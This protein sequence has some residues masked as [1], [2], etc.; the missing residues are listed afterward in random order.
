MLLTADQ[1]RGCGGVGWRDDA[2][3]RCGQYGWAPL[4]HGQT[5]NGAKGFPFGLSIG[6][7]HRSRVT[8]WRIREVLAGFPNPCI[9][10]VLF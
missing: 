4:A 7:V 1:Q 3:F 2:A 9:F 10:L 5:Q 6:T 8:K